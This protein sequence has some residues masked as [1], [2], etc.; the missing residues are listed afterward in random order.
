MTCPSLTQ[1][2]WHQPHVIG[3][4]KL[5]LLAVAH[6]AH[7]GSHVAQTNIR[8]LQVLTG[9]SE[10]AVRNQLTTLRSLEMLTFDPGRGR[11]TRPFRV[12]LRQRSATQPPFP[13]WIKFLRGLRDQWRSTISDPFEG[14]VSDYAEWKST[15]ALLAFFVEALSP[16]VERKLHKIFTD[17]AN[18]MEAAAHMTQNPEHIQWAQDM[19]EWATYMEVVQRL[20]RSLPEP[21]KPACLQTVDDWITSPDVTRLRVQCSTRQLRI[22]TALKLAGMTE[23]FEGEARRFSALRRGEHSF[24]ESQPSIPEG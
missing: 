3:T 8:E 11:G 13:T 22:D 10:S 1:A 2:V 4:A 24:T 23:F 9:L 18:Y 14:T 12:M 21:S 15:E 7:P 6:L 5:V 16:E 20:R 17:M 19:R